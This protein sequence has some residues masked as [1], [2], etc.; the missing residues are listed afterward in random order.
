MA[1]EE[2]LKEG[3]VAFVLRQI[4]PG[5]HSFNWSYQ[6]ARHSGDVCNREQAEAPVPKRKRPQSQTETVFA[7]AKP[8]AKILSASGRPI[9][10]SGAHGMTTFLSSALPS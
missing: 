2:E 4:P 6:I 8:Y 1:E 5:T 3:M 10:Q 9:S 7:A